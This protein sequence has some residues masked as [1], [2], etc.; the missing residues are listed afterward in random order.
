[1]ATEAG[2]WVDHPL[3]APAAGGPWVVHHGDRASPAAEPPPW[4]WPDGAAAS[5]GAD[6]AT[7]LAALAEDAAGGRP[8]GADRS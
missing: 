4:P 5:L 6:N 8:G 1:V 2:S 3:D 7:V